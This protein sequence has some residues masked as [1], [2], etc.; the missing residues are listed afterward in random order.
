MTLADL[1]AEALAQV[2]QLRRERDEARVEVGRLRALSSFTPITECGFGARTLNALWARGFRVLGDVARKTRSELVQMRGIGK[3][4]ADEIEAVI[5]K[6]G[7]VTE[8]VNTLTHCEHDGRAF[9]RP[10]PI[11]ALHEAVAAHD[12]TISEL[13]RLRCE[14]DEARAEVGRLERLFQQT[15]GVHHTW[16]D[17]RHKVAERQREACA[18]YLR[19]WAYDDHALSRVRATPLVTEGEP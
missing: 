4:S 19:H 17:A 11:C 7:C 1:K 16:V 6:A 18:D 8:G 5:E 15:H 3:V 10:C 13:V 14:R 2:E 12:K 9:P